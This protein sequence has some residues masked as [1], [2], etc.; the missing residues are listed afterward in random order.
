MH[1][2]SRWLRALV[3]VIVG[4]LLAPAF[5]AVDAQAEGSPSIGLSVAAPAS[6]L[7]G[8]NAT[9]TLTAANPGTQPYGYNL[10]YRAVLPEGV[11]YVAGSGHT[12]AGA[13]E[14]QTYAN[15]PE[16]GKTTLV[17]SNVSDLSPGSSNAL[18]F[19]VKP[20]TAHFAIG[21]K[22]SIEAGAYVSEQARYLPKFSAAGVPEGPSSTSYT[23]FAGG[24][25]TSA[26]T[27]LQINQAEES[28]QGQILRGV[29]DHQVTYK[30]TVTNTNVNATGK[31]LVEDWLP[32]DLEYLGCG[33]AGADHTTDAPTNP[34]SAEEYP[35]SGPILVA[36]LG[37]C[38]TPTGVETLMTDPDGAEEDPDAVYTHVSWSL[39]TLAA[40]ETR[41]FEFRAA[42]PLRENTTT[43]TAKEPTVASGEQATNLNNNSGKETTDGEAVSTYAKASGDY[44][45]TTPVSASEHLTRTAKD[46]TIE[47]S[48]GA[49]TLAQGQVTL[50]T[51]VLHSSEYR[52][53]TAAV[54]TDTVPNGLCPLSSENLTKSAEC[55]PDTAPSSPYASAVEEAN[56]TWK[57]VWSEASDKALADIGPNASTTITYD[58]RTRTH[59]QHEHAQTGPILAD[60]SVTN[61]V[62]AQT[63]TNVV[64][65][66]D[67][68][69][70]GKGETP[71]NH[72][73]PLS[74]AVSAGSSASQSSE[75]PSISKE[76]AKSGTACL[77][78]EYT[79]SNPVFHPGDLICW[80]LIASFPTTIDTKGLNV[81]DFLPIADT[82]DES[83]EEDKEKGQARAP[84]DTLPS[85]TFNHSEASSSEPGGAIAWKLPEEGYVNNEK[86]R[87]ERVYA[88]IARLP[89]EASSGELQGNLMKFANVNTAG[90][91]F[92][93]RAE[94]DYKLQFPQLSLAKQIVEINKKA[95]TPTST[96]TIKADDEATFAL[97]VSNAGKLEADGVEVWDELPDGIT[98]EDI[99]AISAKGACGSG[100]IEWG[101]THLGEEEVKVAA[102]GAAVLHFTVRIPATIDPADTLED[103]AGVVKYESATNTGGQ[104]LYVPAE[105][106]DALRDSEANMPAANAQAAL[107]TEDVKLEKTNT[108]SV[109]ETGNTAAQATIG[110]LITYEVSVTIPAGT[111]LSGIAKLTDPALPKEQL[112]LKAGSDEALVNGKAAPVGFKAEESSGSPLVVFPE[113]YA[114]PIEESVKVT[115]RFVTT[116]ANVAVNVHGKS[117]AN[118]GKLTWTDPITGA[119]AREASDSVPVV[120]PV[121]TLTEANNTGG[122]PAHGGQLVEYK[123]K[124][125]DAEGASTAF[126]TTVVDTVPA[127]MTVS[128]ASGKPYAEGETIESGGVWNEKAR[129][130]TWSVTSI[131][132]N[133]EAALVY[134]AT[135]NEKPV[136]ATILT[137]HAV[138]TTTSMSGAVS[139]KRS[140]ENDP[141][142]GKAG[143]EA[144]AESSLEVAGA[145]IEK[146]SDSAKATIGHRVTYTL[147]VTLPADVVA[148]NETVIDTLPSSLDFDEYIS[149]ECTSGCPPAVTVQTYKPKVN[150]SNTTSVAWYLGN[151]EAASAP[152]TITIVYCADVRPTYRGGAVAV[153]AGAEISN[154]ADIYY[155]KTN[156]HSFEEENIPAPAEFDA[157]NG[158][159]SA[160]S[161]VV[162][163][164]VT[165]TKE[166]SVNGG[167][168]SAGPITVT[169][170][171]SVRYRLKL[172]NTGG[173]AAYGVEAKDVLPAQLTEVKETT[174]SADVTQSWSEGKPEIHWKLKEPLAANSSETVELGY[175]AKLVSVKSLE[176]GEE[177][178]NSA[179]VPG[180]YFGVPEAER[181]AG[182]KNYAGEAIAYREY[183]GPTAAV[184]A[185]V[186][187]PT[188]T[189]TKTTGA[190]GFPTSA[191]AEVG[192][193]FTWRVLVKNTSTVAA[194]SVHVADTLP[195]N[196]EY[197][198]GATF[199]KGG[200]I[201]PAVSGSVKAGEE[202]TWATSIELAGGT[203]TILTYQAKPLLEAESSPGIGEAHPNKNSASVS[204]LDAA[205]HAED[206][207]GPFAAGPAQAQ[208]ILDV[209]VL[210]VK[211]QPAKESIAAGAEDSYKITIHNSGAGVAREVLAEDKLPAGMSYKAKSATASPSTGFS[212]KSASGSS[213]VW[214]IES[215]AAGASV[216]ITV[217]VDTE[218]TLASGTHLTNNVAVHASAATTPVEASG[219]IAL[220]ASADISAAKKVVSAGKAVP[221]DTLTYEISAT[222]H[223]PSTAHEVKLVDHLP[224]GLTYKSSSAGCTFSEVTGVVTCVAGTVEPGQAK[225]FQ[226][227]VQLA[228]GLTGTVSNTVRAESTTPDPEPANNEATAKTTLFPQAELELKKESLTPEVHDGEEARFLLTATNGGPS[229]AAETKIVDTLPAGLEY[230]SASGV[231]ASCEPN[232]AN[233]Q[234]V[235]CTFAKAVAVNA[236]V[237]LQLVT[238]TSGPGTRVNT[239]TVTSAAEDLEPANNTAKA[240]VKVLPSADL[241]LRKTA[242]VPFVKA[243]G[244]VTYTLT[245]ENKGPDAAKKVAISDELPAGEK[246]LTS[247]S[248]CKHS[249]QDVI[250]EEVGGAELASG[251]S[252]TVQLTVEMEVALAEHTVINSAE[253]SSETFD[254]HLANNKAQ[255]EVQ[256]ETAADL[257]LT[258][259]ATPTSVDVGGE[260]TYTLLAANAGP[261]TVKG[262]VVTDMLPAGETY[263]G[264]DAGCMDEG[265]T[266]TCSLGEMT[267]GATHTIHIVVRIGPTLADQKVANTAEATSETPD[268]DEAN[269]EATAEI[270]V[271]PAADLKLTKTVAIEGEG[272]TLP[273]PGKATYTLL[274]ENLGPDAA[275]GVVVSDPLPAG[276]SYI[277]SD[278]GCTAAGQT[279]TCALGELADGEA[280]TIQLTVLVG[281]SLGER[282]VT[283]IA[284]VSSATYDPSPSE[285]TSSAPL[286]T[287][288]TADIA[289]E[290][291]GPT[292][293][294]SSTAITWSLKIK[295]NGPSPAQDVTVE[296]PLPGGVTLTHAA[297]TQGGCQT[298]GSVL[299]CDL[300]T[301][302][303]GATAEVTV[304][305]TVTATS[306]TLQNT[307]KVSALEPDPEPANNSSTATTTVLPAQSGVSANTGADARTQVSLRKLA[308]RSSVAPGGEIVY[309]L[310]VRDT[311][312]APAR[313]VRVCDALPSQTTVVSRGGAHLRSERLCFARFTLAP[314]R[315]RT[316]KIVLR[317]D[318]NA[319]QAILNR[320]SVSGAN[321]DTVHVHV[322]T[323]V[324]GSDRALRESGVTG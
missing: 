79:T 274:V 151:I 188:I 65:D 312:S 93:Y 221:G 317:A 53:N 208:G 2:T 300:G 14:P 216:E 6:V 41:T 269:N 313:D 82:F 68:N 16:K 166:A 35:G 225:A 293:V 13:F 47:K 171:A 158:P 275:A 321:F 107:K 102:E 309:R 34:G 253:A 291:T 192:Q 164:A 306:G 156:K 78:D 81:T 167:A 85:T 105:N 77:A 311:G 133:K 226:I 170:G 305:A 134:F 215:I 172:A 27:A 299:T 80:R 48:A 75:G 196:W 106:I 8:A 113:G 76:I 266:V 51:L 130:I 61:S 153:K 12:P 243:N 140:A 233:R 213:I 223:G 224:A 145:T 122:K 111:T 5:L 239:A 290:K 294:V 230:V 200:A 219:T 63:T 250:C 318:S 257:Q 176:P 203:E 88:T 191:P 207:K 177:F 178:A 3:A 319:R 251:N 265:Q 315:S 304:T 270:A 252:E 296:D 246:L 70:S 324:R 193:A 249:G 11:S 211:K 154:S 37:G 4:A 139:G 44:A 90:Q 289:I 18:S 292:S 58:T 73:R 276:E 97:T 187:L 259:A 71:I 160:T 247:S 241:A 144:K 109:V 201:E 248:I 165:L 194:K 286:Q 155:N 131:E 242:S 86:Q 229:E 175:E 96:A 222:N 262:A 260:V 99:T 214:E 217:P 268:P 235:T 40:G 66:D 258:K 17:W 316:F 45:E 240:E 24:S 26:I 54:V 284:S 19:E 227:V 98:C 126:D 25:A 307:A 116:V 15:E 180:H 308:D 23:G 59:Y 298:A 123:L 181:E 49:K 1:P 272:A 173:V 323:T 83:F 125:K 169:D 209:P 264:N 95:V 236:S 210:E 255:A 301:L 204:V 314:G 94:A 179:S 147:T 10:S 74:E 89:R 84:G 69:C 124:A 28:P 143:Y 118:T 142:S 56:G 115:M 212:E 267:D 278:A 112:T 22:F 297:A 302:A 174:G 104:Y 137:D 237:S 21:G 110:E 202:L 52:Y 152:R 157:K 231:G 138:A 136:S 91:S 31:V 150:G 87:F 50:W 218:A 279:V 120:E 245:V 184:K 149:A 92:S 132:P 100:R 280:R 57:L 55:E 234:E 320:A 322:S 161:A 39:G 263:I 182:Y 42:V 46:I 238:H 148:Y 108:S 9:V 228:P 310:V 287:G 36:A 135:V 30:L 185:K 198:K 183:T 146:K 199:S 43:W 273:L 67:T 119:Q 261:D 64:C 129:T 295:D 38:L 141:V 127:G 159:A 205:G 117:I 277:S 168:Y 281:L 128:N 190:A 20:A 7:Y 121:I 103:H 197:V 60:D 29:H 32:A 162:E 62:L 189:L 232:K 254:P 271:E 303:D 101:E 220:T 114:A 244:E 186:A 288:P 282:I 206:A 163:P 33:G 285:S 72:E 283:N 256:V 195:A